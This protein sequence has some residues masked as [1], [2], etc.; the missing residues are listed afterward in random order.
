MCPVGNSKHTKAHSHPGRQS[1]KIPDTQ[2]DL[3]ASLDR[4]WEHLRGMYISAH[5]WWEEGWL[6]SARQASAQQIVQLTSA[7][8]ST[9]EKL[10][11]TEAAGVPRSAVAHYN[12][13]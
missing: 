5:C 3:R 10:V 1:N 9:F 12:M 11:I 7:L 13:P 6:K 4:G 8:K 2:S